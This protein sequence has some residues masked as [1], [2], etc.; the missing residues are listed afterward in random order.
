MMRAETKTDMTVL[1]AGTQHMDAPIVLSGEENPEWK[2]LRL[3]FRSEDESLFTSLVEIKG[4]EFKKVEGKPY[5]TY[6]LPKGADGKYPMFYD[7]YE[8]GKRM[9]HATSPIWKNPF[10]FLPEERRSLRDFT[11]LWLTPRRRRRRAVPICS[12]LFAC[13]GSIPFSA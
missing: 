12:F 2:K 10:A 5:Y 1:L 13:N 3:T 7:L 8:E 11:C 9:T 6:Q 4:S